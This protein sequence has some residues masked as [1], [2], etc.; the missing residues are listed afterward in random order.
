MERS[1]FTACIRLLLPALLL[2]ALHVH[3]GNE[4]YYSTELDDAVNAARRNPVNTSYVGSRWY[5]R[6]TSRSFN[7]PPMLN[8][9][10]DQQVIEGAMGPTAA[11][12]AAAAEALQPA[13]D[14]ALGRQSKGDA[15]D[16]SVSD[17]RKRKNQKGDDDSAEPVEIIE[18]VY[19]RESRSANSAARD[20]RANSVTIRATSRP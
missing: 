14:A 20:V 13:R 1:C 17:T 3:A 8:T 19:I 2:P 7:L 15:L 10:M 11:G 16:D 12:T 6:T 9:E 5:N 18:D 4:A